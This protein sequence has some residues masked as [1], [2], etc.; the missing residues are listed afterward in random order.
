MTN[1]NRIPDAFVA[2]RSEGF[3]IILARGVI[4]RAARQLA[5]ATNAAGFHDAMELA[6]FN[7]TPKPTGTCSTASPYSSHFTAA[8]STETSGLLWT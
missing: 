3:E 7:S 6:W 5:E 4:E 2:R 8:P 1:D